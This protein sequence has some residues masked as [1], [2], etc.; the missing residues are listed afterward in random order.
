[1]WNEE[2]GLMPVTGSRRVVHQETIEVSQKSYDKWSNGVTLSVKS[3][4][5]LYALRGGVE[6]Q[7]FVVYVSS[8]TR[9]DQ[10]SGTTL[11]L[12]GGT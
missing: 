11:P 4:A 1:M 12:S 9:A 10:S 3:S 7:C 2:D 6:E 5:Y 8:I